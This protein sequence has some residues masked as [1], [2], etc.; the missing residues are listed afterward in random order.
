MVIVNLTFFCGLA[1]FLFPSDVPP[2][3]VS[4]LKC[5]SSQQW[6]TTFKMNLQGRTNLSAFFPTQPQC[7]AFPEATRVMIVT[8][9]QSSCVLSGWRA[10][11][12]RH[13]SNT[14]KG[15]VIHNPVVHDG[16]SCP[17]YVFHLLYGISS[18]ATQHT[19]QW[20]SIIIIIKYSLLNNKT[21]RKHAACLLFS[22]VND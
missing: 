5:Q 20:C 4:E 6:D 7:P 13:W 17:L 22:N 14:K 9:T 15:T 2:C 18:N 21:S 11:W 16:R 3:S 1:L 12:E 10:L 8:S 19:S